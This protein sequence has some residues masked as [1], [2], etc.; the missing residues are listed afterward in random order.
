MSLRAGDIVLVEAEVLRVYDDDSIMVHN[1]IESEGVAG[2]VRQTFR[3]GDTVTVEGNH[4]CEVRAIDGNQA[5]VRTLNGARI[6]VDLSRA[7]RVD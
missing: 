2:V 7:A 6:I 5:M 1:V 3:I 4:M